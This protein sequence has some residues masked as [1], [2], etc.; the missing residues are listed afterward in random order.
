MQG[1]AGEQ[2]ERV[3]LAPYTATSTPGRRSASAVAEPVQNMA[4]RSS[5]TSARSSSISADGDGVLALTAQTLTDRK[6]SYY[7]TSQPSLISK[8]VQLKEYQLIGVNWLNLLYRKKLSC[9]LADEM[10]E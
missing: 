1:R 10:G 2:S 8:G 7:L 4:T 3:G 9:I 5:S 6:P